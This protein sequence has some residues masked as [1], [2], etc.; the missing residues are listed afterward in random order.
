MPKN[1]TNKYNKTFLSFIKSVVTKKTSSG[2]RQNLKY[3][4]ARHTIEKDQF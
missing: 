3:F 1:V 2:F 4:G